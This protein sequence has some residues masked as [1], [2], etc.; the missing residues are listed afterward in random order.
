MEKHKRGKRVKRAEIIA[1]RWRI[2]KTV[3]EVDKMEIWF[4]S[5]FRSTT[6]T[7]LWVLDD[8]V[9]GRR[10]KQ[11]F[12]ENGVEGT[13]MVTIFF[14][15]G[16]RKRR[17]KIYSYLFS[18]VRFILFHFIFFSIFYLTRVIGRFFQRC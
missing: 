3:V 10:R 1:Q 18:A 11:I 9:W 15:N 7:R 13:T 2:T 17:K 12:V 16:R 6:T 4:S 5:V 14:R 8:V